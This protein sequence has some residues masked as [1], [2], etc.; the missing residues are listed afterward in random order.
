MFS[1]IF[2]YKTNFYHVF[3]V[4]GDPHLFKWVWVR[5]WVELATINTLT[6]VKKYSFVLGKKMTFLLR[7]VDPPPVIDKFDLENHIISTHESVFFFFC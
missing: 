5:P 4:S 2:L 7:N 3:V 6:F 1:N